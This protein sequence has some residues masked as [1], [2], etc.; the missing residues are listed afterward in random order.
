MQKC[1][2]EKRTYNIES[3]H[4]KKKKNFTFCNFNLNDIDMNEY[5]S[6]PL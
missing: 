3:Q 2:L 4:V 1:S 5:L 6:K